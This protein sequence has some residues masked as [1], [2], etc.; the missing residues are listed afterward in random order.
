MAE[1]SQS[2]AER[3]L[4]LEQI[5]LAFPEGLHK[6]EIARRLGVHRAT[7][8]RYIEELTRR[9]PIW[10]DGD[11]LGIN[12]SNYLTHVRL[13]LNESMA[14]HLAARLMATRT[15][16][17]NPH[18]AS[19]LRK[20]GQ[21]L[22]K[23]APLVSRHLLASAEVM[24][25]IARRHDPVYLEVLE[26]LT[27][28]W[29]DKRM[30][31]L[32]HR[33]KRGRVYEYNFAPYFIEPYAVGR[34]AH[35]IGWREPPGE[36]RT[37]KLERIQRIE[38][39]KP[40]REYDVPENFDPRSL[41]VD[42]W[43]IWYTEGEPVEVVL[44]FHPRVAE[45][46]RETQWHHS[47]ETEEQPD[48]H[49]LWRARVA[50]P[51]E[52]M[53]W[54]R[55][56]GADV[57]VLEPERLREELKGH[58]WRMTQMY[59]LNLQSTDVDSRLLRL[60]GKTT[61]DPQQFHPALYH[62]FD[63]AHV[64]QQ[65]LSPRASS[66]WRRVLADALNADAATL[67]EWLPYL[68]ALHD[69][70]KISTLF[71]ILNDEQYTRLKGEGFSFGKTSRNDGRQL[72]HTIIGRLVLKDTV[73]TWPD[74]LRKAVI[75]MIS[76]H[77]GQFQS[78]ETKDRRNFR[79][80]REGEEWSQLRQRAI[81]ILQ[82]YLL[83][84][85]PDPM[86]NP[87]NLSTAMMALTGFCILCDWLGSDE[88]YFSPAPYVPLT[89]YI[90]KSRRQ[91][92][93]CVHEA[94]FFQAA[95]SD[96]PTQ[97][98]ALFSDIT[99][100]RP[101]Q[102]A[103]DDIPDDLLQSPT[104]TIIEAPTGE[105]K[106]EAAL[107]LAR[108]I[109]ALRGTD[110]M[111]IALPTT[112]TSNAMFGRIQKHMQ[113]RLHLPPEMVKLVHGQ[114]FLVEDDLRIAPMDSVEPDGQTESPSMAWFSP[115]KKALLAPVGVGTIDQAELS[116]LNVRHNALRMIG[117]AGKT[118]IL[119]EVHAY[120]TYMTTIIKR[121]LTW[122][123]ALGSSVILLSATLPAARRKELA[124]AFA[125]NQADAIAD[126]ETYPGLLTIS[127]VKH[128][129]SKPSPYQQCKS[130][131]LYRRNFAHEN[132]VAKA[133]WLIEQAQAGGCIC[134]ITNTVKRAQ[135]IYNAL[136]ELEPADITLD[137]LHARF[138]LTD[139]EEREKDIL[140]KYGRGKNTRRPQK[141]IIVGTQVLE[142]SLDLD[143]DVM[144][145][146]LAPIDLILQRAGR[147]HRHE[148]ERYHHQTPCLYVN[149]L[150]EGAD[151]KI[152]TDYIL[153]QTKRILEEKDTL[154]LPTDYRF[155][156]EAVYNETPPPPDN[157][158]HSA[159]QSLEDKRNH[160][161]VEAKQRLI[162]APSPTVPF[163]RSGKF[164]FRED[165]DSNSWMV[166]QTRWGQE[167]VT[168]IPLVREGDI[169]RI[170]FEQ[171][172]IPLNQKI[173][174]ETQLHLLRHSLRVSHRRLVECIKNSSETF[175]LFT[176]SALLKN[177]FP[178]W[179]EMGKEE[180]V[181]S[182]DVLDVQLHPQLGLVIGKLCQEEKTSRDTKPLEV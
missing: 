31:R 94:G 69:L 157:P 117:L 182:N 11:R 102:T 10:Q 20:L 44:R 144:M 34:T 146:D 62:M 39:I 141:A 6:A 59:A 46:V 61:K 161:E 12:R 83:Q 60:W 154:N 77:H 159:W 35:V 100:P 3:L 76:G 28:A 169:A 93:K 49:L 97:F 48:G 47:E 151:R 134:W 41:L 26:T 127:P 29:A 38:I 37:F 2:K 136:L 99:S 101:L 21:A 95:V 181:W 73:A 103:I 165:E 131:A 162:N 119:D 128:Y 177:C 15:D 152:Y 81:Q 109:S 175:A 52:M 126:F 7:V 116:A 65:L 122:L 137:L 142:Q 132:P 50:E 25:D 105:G 120:D 143:F 130:I 14:L 158:L 112:A 167:S 172:P 118:I 36:V 86:P 91:A 153:Q 51:Q 147:L 171:T 156:I 54:I 90:S 115:K 22:D 178:L 148:R 57:E 121:M 149:M 89:E 107:A 9:L 125:G 82:S 33:H 138:P 30:V 135:K 111:Y 67:D 176:D 168:I 114:N 43:G 53:H 84:R 104:L 88:T 123:S 72:H 85:W 42:A 75:D 87:A 19:A 174:R 133:Q 124:Q 23:F 5:L 4:Q 8:G 155:L 70:G 164:L 110:E 40:P 56:W 24:D 1:R 173:D 98:A 80:V 68:I 16:K 74:N 129:F 58:V 13:T 145:T 163:Y 78:D 106:T 55:G 18:A 71:Q 27:M 66:R 180:N 17:H 92:W 179:L 139:R 113:Q 166:A 108:R 79:R 63:V 170:P 96:A 32:W 45:R 140:K 64:A 160:H 150:I